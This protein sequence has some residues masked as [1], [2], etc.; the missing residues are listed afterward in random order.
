MQAVYCTP[1]V[2]ASVQFGMLAVQ[3]DYIP[4][5]VLINLSFYANYDGKGIDIDL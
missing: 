5:L 2:I 4:Y 1:K 3:K